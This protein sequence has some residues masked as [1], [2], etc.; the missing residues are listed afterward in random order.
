MKGLLPL[1]K[2]WRLEGRTLNYNFGNAPAEAL[3]R[4]LPPP[5]GG[6]V[7]TRPENYLI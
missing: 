7:M 5:S 6:K 3:P 2:A 1:V 4:S